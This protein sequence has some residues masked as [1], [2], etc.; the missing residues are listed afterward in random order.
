MMRY[1]IAIV[2]LCLMHQASQAA[3]PLLAIITKALP[4]IVGKAGAK[5][6]GSLL[7]ESLKKNPF[8]QIDQILG[9]TK[10]MEGD[11]KPPPLSQ[12]KYVFDS[13]PEKRASL[14]PTTIKLDLEATNKA[15]P[16]TTPPAKAEETK[17]EPPKKRSDTL[18]GP[19]KKEPIEWKSK[20]E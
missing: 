19:G 9:S 10:K 8:E 2:C 3:A 6:G 1:L 18:S 5:Q 7:L 15:T 20:K 14:A 12:R 11:L 13:M 4:A 16:A 17:A